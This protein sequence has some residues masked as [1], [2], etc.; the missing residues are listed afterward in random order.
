MKNPFIVGMCG[1]PGTGKTT[2]ATKLQ[3]NLNLIYLN[4]KMFR[5][6]DVP[7]SL[8]ESQIVDDEWYSEAEKNIKDKKSVIMDATFHKYSKR[9]KLYRFSNRLGCDLLFIHCVCNIN[10]AIKRLEQQKFS[11]EKTFY[12]DISRMVFAY[13]KTANNILNDYEKPF[14]LECDTERG[15]LSKYNLDNKPDFIDKIIKVLSK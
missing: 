5:T 2:I 14:I 8:S 7:L 4:P 11:K 15:R 6:T 10:T 12:C 13:I 9:T 1:T 3:N